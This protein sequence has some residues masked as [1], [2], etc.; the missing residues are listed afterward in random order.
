MGL[1]FGH[2]LL[3]QSLARQMIMGFIVVMTGFTLF[4]AGTLYLLDQLGSG[5]DLLRQQ[6]RASAALAR[7]ERSLAV[8]AA[9]LQARQSTSN[10]VD[11]AASS[12][13][14][15]GAEAEWIAQEGLAAIAPYLP[16]GQVLQME[17]AA[18]RAAALT[19]LGEDAAPV[20]RRAALAEAGEAL[21]LLQGGAEQAAGALA[22]A[23]GTLW[24]RQ[25]RL[26]R[27]GRWGTAFIL[28]V[29]L[30]VAVLVTIFFNGRLRGRVQG[31]RA[32]SDT[33][34]G[35]AARAS[36]TVEQLGAFGQEL[37]GT[38]TEMKR[39]FDEVSAGSQTAAS[40]AGRITDAMGDTA[41]E[42]A[43]LR[44]AAHQARE[45]AGRSVEA[46]EATGSQVGRG[47]EEASTMVAAVG[48]VT[49]EA[50]EVQRMVA[51]FAAQMG[52]I[53]EILDSIEAIAGQTNLLALNAAIEAARA[54]EHGRG[55][56]VVA[57]EV[58][59]LA[60]ESG[61]AAG[62]IRQ[63]AQGVEAATRGVVGAVEGIA[64][65]IGAVRTRAGVVAEAL[66]A[67][68]STFET[69]RGNVLTVQ[70]TASRQFDQA[71][72][73][74]RR[75]EEVVATTEEIVAQFQETGAALQQLTEQ[76]H[77]LEAGAGALAQR[78]QEL[79]SEAENQARAAREVH[80][81]VGD[82]A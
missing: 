47:R 44:E 25:E 26:G 71:D 78:L 73:V 63:I 79:Q 31:L 60:S 52:R 74:S 53:S 50:E 58:R 43:S 55:F 3:S 10:R 41:A 32:L 19:G 72:R 45:L 16:A 67:V 20:Q 17:E 77:R 69:L 39:A 70:A 82:L 76:V 48:Q 2:R 1:G 54:G 27:L 21:R 22:Q 28:G 35:G 64:S 81:L 11:G 13:S 56:A 5:L 6:S 37:S 61:E 51:S 9:D 14:I 4:G 42:A 66:E 49:R 29:G 68:G 65:G 23:E 15:F 24:A 7:V 12:S 62:Q 57:A 40:G 8:M 34:A 46:M 59:K 36:R 18:R 38:F 75:A 30:A 80:T 33:A